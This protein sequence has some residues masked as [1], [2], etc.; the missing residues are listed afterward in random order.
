MSD[1]RDALR[2]L[3]AT[4]V[5]SAVAVLSLA[6]GIGAN[7]AIF[8]IVDSLMLRSLPVKDP[9]RLVLLKDRSWTNPIWEQIRDRQDQL[10][11]SVFAWSGTRFNLSESG[12][13]D[14]VSGLWASGRFFEVLGVSA[15]LGRTFTP[16]DDARGGGP[17]GA[18]A[19]ISYDFWQKHFGG[20]ADVVG[21]SLTLNRVA[22]TV[23][24]VTPPG[25]FGPSVG[26]AFDVAVPIGDE[27]LVRPGHS[28]LDQRSW[29]WLNIMAR[30]KPGQ[31]VGQATA[32]LRGVQPQIREAT[33]PP[34]WRPENLREYLKDGLT[35]M[36]AATGAS[37]LRR[38]YEQ[39]LVA[40]MIVVG[41]VLLS[42]AR[43]SPTCCWRG[44][45]R[46]ATR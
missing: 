16:A 12:Q 6:L 26:Q 21:R 34:R 41:L 4:P 29:W 40:I 44:P 43:T 1:V 39:P 7:T 42:R 8:S 19:V 10:F 18:V 27:P 35:L 23:I 45:R 3:R 13:T 37:Y 25:F 17:D 20:A 33:L 32:A 14:F 24:G 9:Q 15:I 2:A 22:F 46:G 28:A 11:Q 5:I 36:P 31:T 30:L 38:R